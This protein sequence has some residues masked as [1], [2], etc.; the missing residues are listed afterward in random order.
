MPPAWQGTETWEEL[1]AVL[2]AM[3]AN[4]I[5]PLGPWRAGLAGRDRL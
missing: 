4:G 3:K 5:T 2:D 1:V